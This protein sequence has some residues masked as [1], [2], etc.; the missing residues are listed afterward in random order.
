MENRGLIL[1]RSD[2]HLLSDGSSF[3]DCILRRL[4]IDDRKENAKEIDEVEFTIEPKQFLD[5]RDEDG[6]LLH[7]KDYQ[8]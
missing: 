3:F 4:G 2:F 1:R 5:I 6:N 7:Y 8:L